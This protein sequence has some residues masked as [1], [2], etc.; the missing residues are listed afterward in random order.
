MCRARKTRS[1]CRRWNAFSPN[2]SPSVD[3]ASRVIF[4]IFGDWKKAKLLVLKSEAMGA[5]VCILF[6]HLLQIWI[7]RNNAEVLVYSLDYYLWLRC[8]NWCCDQEV[9]LRRIMIVPFHFTHS[10]K[11]L[12]HLINYRFAFPLSC[13]LLLSFEFCRYAKFSI[14][15]ELNHSIPS[16]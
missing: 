10:R 5:L 4:E 16:G 7:S 8:N 6:L 15:M 2:P 1:A 12:F 9:R 11:T 13:L 14:L 3:K